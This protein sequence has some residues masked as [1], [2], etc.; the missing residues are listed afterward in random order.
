MLSVLAELDIEETSVSFTIPCHNTFVFTHNQVIHD[1]MIGCFARAFRTPI[2]PHAFGTCV[3]ARTWVDRVVYRHPYMR[4]GLVHSPGTLRTINAV[5]FITDVTVMNYI[6]QM[7]FCS[8]AAT[9]K[10][11]WL[12]SWMTF[13]RVDWIEL[14]RIWLLLRCGPLTLVRVIKVRMRTKYR[15]KESLHNCSSTFHFGYR[16]LTY[17]S[18]CTHISFYDVCNAPQTSATFCA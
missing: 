3:A 2:L 5:A 4:Q 11:Q 1:P 12:K 18:E 6:H 10:L 14:A 15:M 9:T 8:T 16:V 17:S 7:V 13:G